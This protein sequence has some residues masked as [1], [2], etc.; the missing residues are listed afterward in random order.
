MSGRYNLAYYQ[1]HMHNAK[2]TPA[3]NIFQGWKI[4]LPKYCPWNISTKVDGCYRCFSDAVVQDPSK[5]KLRVKDLFSLIVQVT[6]LHGREARTM[7]PWFYHICSQGSERD[8]CSRETETGECWLLTFLEYSLGPHPREWWHPQWEDPPSLVNWIKIIPH[9]HAQKPVTQ[10]VWD[11]IK[12]TGESLSEL[13]RSRNLITALSRLFCHQLSGCLMFPHWGPWAL[14]SAYCPHKVIT[15]TRCQANLKPCDLYPQFTL[16]SVLYQFLP[17]DVLLFPSICREIG[18]AHWS[19]RLLGSLPLSYVCLPS[20]PAWV[21]KAMLS[22]AFPLSQHKGSTAFQN[23]CLGEGLEPSWFIWKLS[24]S[25]GWQGVDH[26]T[27]GSTD[28][29]TQRLALWGNG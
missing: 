20:F 24:S 2:R 9:R 22:Y 13:K 3:F 1:V 11:P 25:G 10:M 19:I 5:S 4:D 8:E 18:T 27:K 21:L 26:N 16:S 6:V 7:G 14:A 29:K 28:L 23:Q 17:V 12:L 15:E